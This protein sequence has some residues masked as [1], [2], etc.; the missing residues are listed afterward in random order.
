MRKQYYETHPVGEG[1]PFFRR[2]K[3]PPPIVK[4][5]AASNLLQ[6]RLGKQGTN[7][8][9]EKGEKGG[10]RGRKRKKGRVGA[11]SSLKRKQVSINKSE[12]TG[13]KGEMK[14]GEDGGMVDAGKE[15][16]KQEGEKKG[17]E[18]KGSS[19]S[20][21]S[22]S[23]S[24]SSTDTEK[25]KARKKAEGEGSSSSSSTT[26]S[27]SS[28][29]GSTSDD[30]KIKDLG[31]AVASLTTPDMTPQVSTM[32]AATT[33]EISATNSIEAAGLS[34]QVGPGVSDAAA[35]SMSMTQSPTSS[36]G[37]ARKSISRALG[38]TLQP[39]GKAKGKRKTKVKKIDLWPN[40]RWIARRLEFFRKEWEEE[41]QQALLL[42][43]KDADG[44]DIEV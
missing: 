30:G 35:N 34:F 37:T 15:Q 17:K 36:R 7:K 21:N 2:L 28:T 40:T 23:S 27:S 11:K 4:P 38:I 18:G 39:K 43:G 24:S 20:S 13:V 19:S 32:T 9:G 41:R 10:K 26:S 3:E 12:T 31:D 33:G 29:S 14:Q 1:H 44:R 25:D 6:S 5:R 8:K 16:G 22:T 42:A